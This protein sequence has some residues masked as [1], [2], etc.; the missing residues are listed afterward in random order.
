M[1]ASQPS[2]LIRSLEETAI[3][4]GIEP[5]PFGQRL[6]ALSFTAADPD[7][8]L[9]N[10]Q[11]YLETGFSA[12]RIKDFLSYPVL[13][14]IVFELMGQSQYLADIL[15]RDPE[16]LRWLTASNELKRTRASSDLLSEAVQSMSLFER[17]ERKLDSLRRLHRREM[18]RIGAREILREGDVETIT[19]ELSALADAATQAV[20]LAAHADLNAR[21]GSDITNELAVIA[22]GKLGGGE[23]NFSSDIDLLFVYEHDG[24][25]ARPAGRLHSY[26]EFYVRLAEQIVKGLSEFTGEGHLYRVDMRLRPDGRSGPLAMSR[27]AMLSYYESR[28]AA[29]ERQM[30]LKARPIAGSPDVGGRFL[31]DI[32]PFLFPRS[33]WRSP[34]EEIAGM[35]RAIEQDGTTEGDIKLGAGGIRDIEFLVQGL[36]LLYAGNDPRLR[37]GH[38]LQAIERLSEA[39]LLPD[40]IATELRQ[41]YTFFR[42]VEHRLQLLHGHQTHQLPESRDEFRIL[43]RKLGFPSASALQA[44]LDRLRTFVRSQFE[45]FTG[46][47]PSGT[48][49][50]GSEPIDA[51]IARAVNE[52][53]WPEQVR[54]IAQARLSTAFALPSSHRL[55]EIAL[56]Q[57]SHREWLVRTAA[58]SSRIMELLAV[59]PLLLESLIGNGQELLGRRSPGWVDLRT[60]DLRRY[61]LY[62]SART[63]IRFLSGRATVRSVESELSELADE[64]IRSVSDRHLTGQKGLALMGVGKLGGREMGFASDLDLICVYDE[65][66]CGRDEAERLS[67]NLATEIS[68]TLSL[69]T[70]DFRLRPEG[71]NSPLAVEVGYLTS[72][73]ADR[74]EPWERMALSRAR[75]VWGD[76]IFGARVLRKT[77]KW[78][79]TPIPGLGA[80]VRR[81]RTAMEGERV[82]GEVIDVKV[83]AGGVADPEFVAQ[84]LALRSP[85]LLGLS[86]D[87]VLQKCVTR[88]RIDRTTGSI[89]REGLNRLR[90]VEFLVRLNSATSTSVLPMDVLVRACVATA[91]DMKGEKQLM[92][93]ISAVM[94]SN[95]RAFRA[96]VRTIDTQEKRNR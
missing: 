71:K 70:V 34:W 74:A 6:E 80:Y 2:L 19:A 96:A 13:L 88:R 3:R 4:Q 24:E 64:V 95:R 20:V 51:L 56:Q 40:M 57:D 9:R 14:E 36:Q 58:G 39:R 43:G 90:S 42:T 84:A 50:S 38:T 55:L 83:S 7:R 32:R 27:A 62:N 77:R 93:M 17:M 76:R 12:G 54:S 63:A 16:L 87:Q 15:V 79:A 29:W 22:L 49:A 31:S 82:R 81:M 10:L 60:N 41:A 26:H 61:G 5:G 92:K 78:L 59:E 8:A 52:R 21:L 89:L 33:S 23:L 47:S 18:L 67:R 45:A 37:T 91:M 1:P 53:R 72:Y 68:A 30:L 73:L 25:L 75:I 69:Y 85:D 11:R 28:G 44:H 86:A 35:K 65:R 66:T 94:R 46:S 48:A